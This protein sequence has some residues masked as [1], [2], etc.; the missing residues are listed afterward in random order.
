MQAVAFYE[1]LKLKK[2]RV[3]FYLENANDINLKKTY[4]NIITYSE[5]HDYSMIE[6]IFMK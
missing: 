1:L 2:F 4:L 3:Q 5:W 6:P